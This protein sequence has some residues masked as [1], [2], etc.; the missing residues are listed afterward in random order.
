[1]AN[2]VLTDA[3]ASDIK[4]LMAWFPDSA[5][6]AA[7]GGP[8]FRFPFT[9]SIFHEDCHWREMASLVLRDDDG[10][11]EAFGQLYE[12]Y[13]RINLARI[14]VHPERRGR[15]LGRQLISALITEGERLFSL[16]EF[17]LFVLS[18]NSAALRLYFSLGFVQAPY[19]EGA[20]LQDICFYMTR[21]VSRS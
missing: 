7:W 19:P 1:M 11:T 16:A 18:N 10:F 9:E 3:E 12:R 20:P 4:Q 6:T 8:R 21:P 15:G 13:G 2:R 17:S 5:A 14:A